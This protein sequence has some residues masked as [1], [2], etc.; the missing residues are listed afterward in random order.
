LEKFDKEDYQ[1]IVDV[2]VGLLENGV[3]IQGRL[4]QKVKM[5]AKRSDHPASNAIL[6]T[7]NSA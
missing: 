1:E 3:S 6:D 4:A 5:A 7:V 2:A